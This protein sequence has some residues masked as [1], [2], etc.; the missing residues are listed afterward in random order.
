MGK[1]ALNTSTAT[2]FTSEDGPSLMHLPLQV[3]LLLSFLLIRVD[4]VANRRCRCR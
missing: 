1:M 2:F 4:H 3:D